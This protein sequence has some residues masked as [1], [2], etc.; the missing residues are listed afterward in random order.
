MVVQEILDK[1]DENG[2]GEIDFSEFKKMVVS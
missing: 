1:V 2:D